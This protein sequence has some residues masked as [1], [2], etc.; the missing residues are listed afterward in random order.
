MDL[1]KYANAQSIGEEDIISLPWYQPY[2]F[3]DDIV[4]GVAPQFFMKNVDTTIINRRSHPKIFKRFLNLNTR[5]GLMYQDWAKSVCE[6]T[7]LNIKK[8]DIFEIA[9]NT[10]Y[11]LFW[12]KEQGAQNC[13]GIDKQQ[14]DTQRNILRKITGIEGVDF[15]EG[16]W[17][18][19]THLL[20]G[21]DVKEQFDVVICTAFAQHISDPLHL[22]RELG[23]RT[24]K[25]LLFHN[26][27]G[28]LNQGMSIRYR[29][30]EHHQRWGDVFPNNLDTRI[31]R[32][33]LYWSLKECGFKEIIQLK[34]SRS[35]LPRLW[36]NQFATL[37]CIK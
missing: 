26:S 29:P 3:S 14:L 32:K 12:F 21:L 25:V 4:S 24:K 10:G 27:V 9:C 19:E 37:V 30:V 15:R 18:S 34:Y 13:V 5:M 6:L 22:I 20:K 35:W 31:S 28:Y 7:D 17:D 11:L 16:R 1:R 8:S 2:I 36:Y 23:N 33:L